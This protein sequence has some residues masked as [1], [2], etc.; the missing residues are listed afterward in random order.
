MSA[1]LWAVQVAKLRDP[2]ARRRVGTHRQ[3]ATYGWRMAIRPARIPGLPE[4]V[5]VRRS[6][7]RRRSVAAYREAGKTIVVVPD[8][9]RNADVAQAASEL[10]AKLLRKAAKPA[11]SD[12]SL[13][14]RADQLRR[15]YLPE[16]RR[17]ASIRWSSQQMRRWGSCTSVDGSIR[18]SDRLQNMPQYVI[19][20][21]IV[22]EL[23]H[24]QHANHGREFDELVDRLPDHDLAVSF[25][26]G[27]EFARANIPRPGTA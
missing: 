12:D 4:G 2:Q 11:L 26:A 19:D 6:D 24:L 1:V 7:R 5:A 20:Y 22:H 15:E 23:A 8:R 3:S 21:V 27:F 13:A 25:L 14:W 18:L 16:V 9:M 10:H 17:P